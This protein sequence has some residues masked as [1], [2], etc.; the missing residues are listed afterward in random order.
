MRIPRPGQGEVPEH[1]RV[2]SLV[3]GA[4]GRQGL[5]AAPAPEQGGV[6]ELV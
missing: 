1:R 2:C 5:P 6:R 3:P 4:A